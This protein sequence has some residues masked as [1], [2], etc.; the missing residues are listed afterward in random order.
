MFITRAR[1]HA[2]SRHLLLIG[3]Y[4][5][6][7]GAT[8]DGGHDGLGRLG[9]GEHSGGRGP[10]SARAAGQHLDV[11]ARDG[12]GDAAGQELHGFHD[13]PIRSVGG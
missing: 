3:R 5:C 6:R 8:G 9:G 10:R 7:Y 12:G 11:G 4:V 13:A 1:K 2:E